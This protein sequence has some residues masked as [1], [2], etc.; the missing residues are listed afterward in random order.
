L[1]Y[2]EV[3]THKRKKEREGG[4]GSEREQ[5]RERAVSEYAVWAVC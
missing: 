1:Q 2:N 5:E 3:L 4:R